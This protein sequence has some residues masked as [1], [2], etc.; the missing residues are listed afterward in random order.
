MARS[1]PSDTDPAVERV[2][3]ARYREASPEQKIAMVADGWDC[4]RE[5]TLAGLRM[6][7]P[8]ASEHELFRRFVDIVLGADLAAR[9]Y[10]ALE[11][12]T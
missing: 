2:L 5:L 9:A 3:L 1:G 12:G 4:T 8:G 11:T 6:R 7:H 10:G